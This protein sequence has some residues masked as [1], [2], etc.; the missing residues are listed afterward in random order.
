MLV[1]L[2]VFN[3]F[4]EYKYS[5]FLQKKKFLRG[6]SLFRGFLNEIKAIKDK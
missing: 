5:C 2:A 1:I 3:P 6:E 4:L